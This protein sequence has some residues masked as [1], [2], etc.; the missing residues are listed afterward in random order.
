MLF[1]MYKELMILGICGLFLFVEEKYHFLERALGEFDKH[2]FEHV[3][4]TLFMIVVFYIIVTCCLMGYSIYVAN[5]Y[6]EIEEQAKTESGE[7]KIKSEWATFERQGKEQGMC[8][9]LLNIPWNYRYNQAY[10]RFQYV[11]LRRH[12]IEQHR[13]E[14]PEMDHDFFEFYVYLRKCVRQACIGI[15][16]IHWQVWLTILAIVFLNTVRIVAWQTAEVSSFVIL[17]SVVLWC[18]TM[19]IFY[20]RYNTISTIKTL[21]H[22]YEEYSKLAPSAHSSE[23]EEEEEADEEEAKHLE[24]ERIMKGGP[25]CC[26]RKWFGKGEAHIQQKLFPC[27]SPATTSRGIQLALLLISISIPLYI[28]ELSE[29][30]VDSDG[31]VK[32]VIACC[33]GIP[34]VLLLTLGIPPII[35]RFVICSS[36]AAM[37]RPMMIRDTI[38]KLKREAAHKKKHGH[39]EEK[40][41]GCC[42]KRSKSPKGAKHSHSKKESKAKHHQEHDEEETKGL[43]SSED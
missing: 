41:P 18:V 31:V 16:M 38:K 11:E 15:A 3:H 39:K 6:K 7:R 14:F 20:L 29:T 19:Y 36:V 9:H 10:L 13:A 17:D 37:S 21:T 4:M 40:E 1:K 28:L 30:I 42:G 35:P 27:H 23:Q 5:H 33:I 8:G 2:I 12:F 26:G 25:G 43:N 24:D 34:P 32:I 22:E